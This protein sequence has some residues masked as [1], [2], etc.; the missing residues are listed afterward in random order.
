M[1]P[2]CGASL[3]QLLVDPWTEGYNRSDLGLCHGYGEGA[4]DGYHTQRHGAHTTVF[5]V[6]VE[7]VEARYQEEI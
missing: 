3:T 5:N 2:S 7:G 6:V 4:G 1:R